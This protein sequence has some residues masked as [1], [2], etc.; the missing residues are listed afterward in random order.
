MTKTDLFQAIQFHM[1][2]QFKCQNCPI[3]NNSIL[4]KYTIKV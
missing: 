3:S 4:D 2:T 1:N